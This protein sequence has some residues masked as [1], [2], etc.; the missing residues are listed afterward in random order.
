MSRLPL[1]ALLSLA[2]CSYSSLDDE[3]FPRVVSAD[4][5]VDRTTPDELAPIRIRLELRGGKR[6]ASQALLDK[7]VLDDTFSDPLIDPATEL[8]RLD[9]Q[10]PDAFDAYIGES[11]TKI[12][13]LENVGTLSSDLEPLCGQDLTLTVSIEDANEMTAW[14]LA[15]APVTVACP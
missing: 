13:D 11:E 6:A 4:V 1:L 10:F 2:A 14:T 7:V 15:T 8:L 12:V 9:V 3:I 5:A